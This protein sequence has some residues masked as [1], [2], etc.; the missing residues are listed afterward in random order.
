MCSLDSHEILKNKAKELLAFGWWDI[1]L[2]IK[3]WKSH[4]SLFLFVNLTKIIRLKPH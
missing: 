1:I 2:L 3:T 4:L